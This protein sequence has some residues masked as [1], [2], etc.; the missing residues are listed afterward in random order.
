MYQ[1]YKAPCTFDQRMGRLVLLVHAAGRQAR[2]RQRVKGGALY[3][4]YI[5]PQ[6][7]PEKDAG[8]SRGRMHQKYRALRAGGGALHFR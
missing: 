7:A 4:W 3:F 6:G 5:Q 2:R 8:A 1:K